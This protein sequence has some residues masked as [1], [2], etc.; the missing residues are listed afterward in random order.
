M[1]CAQHL[2]KNVI[3][4]HLTT[5]GLLL[6][7][8]DADDPEISDYHM[9]PS[10]AKLAEHT[11]S[12]LQECDEIPSDPSVLFRSSLFQFDN[13][14]LPKVLDA[15]KDLNMKHEPL[16]L[17]MPRFETP[18]APLQPAVFPPSF[19]E[20]Q[21]PALE[22]F[23]LDEAFSTEKARLAQLTN[24][25]SDEDIEYFIRECGDVLNVTDKLPSDKRDGKHILEYITSQVAEFKK[26]NHASME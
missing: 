22:L 1:L 13:K 18:L 4:N 17:I 9:I 10:I 20:L 24:K 8:I 2:K 12:C 6:N 21:K 14:V 26:L 19:R 23:D 7:A 15:Y 25:C 5:S 11:F 3:F 16:K